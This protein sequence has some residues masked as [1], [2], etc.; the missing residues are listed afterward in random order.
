MCLKKQKSIEEI[1]LEINL[2]TDLLLMYSNS[3]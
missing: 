1:S 2:N 3:K